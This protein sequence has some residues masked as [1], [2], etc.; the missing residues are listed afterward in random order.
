M[1]VVTQLP[2][3]EA[4]PTNAVVGSRQ[5]WWSGS[6]TRGVEDLVRVL[7]EIQRPFYVVGQA[8]A[9]RLAFDGLLYGA[10]SPPAGQAY[11]V[12]AIIPAIHPG[13]LGDLSFCRDHGIR[14]PY[15][16]GSMA[17]GIASVPLVRA[18]AHAG[19]LGS[20]GAAGLSL[21][22][23]DGALRELR[24]DP[25][26]GPWCANLIHSPN[27]KG[28]EEATVELYLRHGLR[29]VEASAYLALTLPVVRYR[30]HG[31]HANPQGE[32]VTPNRII[33][34]AARIEVAGKWFSP[35]PENLLR[36]LV[37]AGQIS[38]TQAE[39]AR[40][41]PMAE[42]LTVEADSGGH[43]DNRP[44]IT[45]L[46]T[47]L[48]LRDRMQREHAYPC[49]LRVGAA[50]GIATPISAAAA[51]AMGAAYIV[52]G[53]INQACIESGSSDLA[54]TMLA[55]AGQADT[56]MAPA[57]DMFEMGVK[58]QVLKRGTLFPMRANKL[59][60]YYRNY[61]SIE[62]IPAKDRET[63]EQSIFRAPLE[64]IWQATR[65]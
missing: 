35:P 43:T 26:A 29:L 41:I 22:A 14:L 38:S 25:G 3:H 34:K 57:V 7:R 39:L 5:G 2:A 51:F 46:P 61:D 42:D 49:R 65:A 19:M 59:Y 60:E 56:A 44:A 20:F 30:V 52:T 11:P 36:Q 53:T 58:L 48:A 12:L 9:M 31:I 17:N 21:D 8:G 45:L 24:G 55:E 10:A 13:R 6:D 47:M 40:R 32:I 16:T 50:G 37:E 27:E 4:L 33:A 63:L 18:I 64:E 1:T 62:A 28:K 54:R 15:M 23:I